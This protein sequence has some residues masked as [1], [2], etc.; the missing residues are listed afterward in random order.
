MSITANIF[1]S[2]M[3]D[4]T[5]EDILSIKDD[6]LV[7]SGLLIDPMTPISKK[8]EEALDPVVFSHTE[9][10]CNRLVHLFRNTLQL[11]EV[12]HFSIG[13]CSELTNDV[14]VSIIEFS[15]YCYFALLSENLIPVKCE[16]F[17]L[18]GPWLLLLINS[19]MI[20]PGGMLLTTQNEKCA[21][22]S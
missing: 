1:P 15:E 14:F 3:P 17:C 18:V 8:L 7:L 5:T 12:N 21:L 2:D 19:S 10:A 11:E 16:S 20:V 6:F 9:S 13:L 4:K 22:E